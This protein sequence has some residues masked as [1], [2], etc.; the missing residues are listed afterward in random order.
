MTCLRR[1]VAGLL[2]A[3]GVTA[4]A[5]TYPLGLDGD[6]THW[7]MLGYL[8][9]P[10]DPEGC[11]ANFDKEL[12]AELGGEAGIQPAAGQAV[13]VGPKSYVWQL[14]PTRVHTIIKYGNWRPWVQLFHG[15]QGEPL[16]HVAAFL[17]T[18]VVCAEATEGRLMFGTDDGAKLYLNGQL[19][20]RH[21]Q[22]R[23]LIQDDETILLPLRK[24]ANELVFRVE[25]YGGYGGIQARLVDAAGSPLRNVSIELSGVSAGTPVLPARD[26]VS[27]STLIAAIPPV[28]AAENPQPFGVRLART[29]ALLASGRVTRRPVKL[30]FY[31][32]SIDEQ[33]WNTLLVNGLRER[34][35]DTLI[36][37]ENYAIGGWGVPTLLKRF[38][39]D[40][41][42]LQPDLVAFHAYGGTESDWDRLLSAIR[43]ETT[44]DILIRTAHEG[45]FA[46]HEMPRI[47]AMYDSEVLVL[48]GLACRYGAELVEVR[49]EWLNYLAAHRLPAAALLSDAIHLNHKGNVLMAQLYERHFRL[50]PAGG[51]GWAGR[52]RR[53][54]AGRS[55]ADRKQDE[56]TLSGGGWTMVDGRVV[57]AS[58]NDALTLTFVGNRAD[59]VLGPC[60]GSARV[61]ID[62]QPPSALN[63]FHGTGPMQPKRYEQVPGRLIRYFEGAGLLEET[64]ELRFKDVNPD[65]RLFRFTLSG[66]KTGADGEGDNQHEFV[67][68][69]GRIA[70]SP[71]DWIL[72]GMPKPDS[73]QPPLLRWHT[74]ADHR[75]VVRGT[76]GKPREGMVPIVPYTY[77]TLADGL[78]FGRH[79][80]TLI[81]VGDA[82]IG[83]QAVEIHRPPLGVDRG[84]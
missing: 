39:H 28:P 2:L 19:V 21:P 52:V 73:A 41:L 79:T 26:S 29:M 23:P 8:P 18:R 67:S 82:P 44:A 9:I 35:P 75:D 16:L 25:N 53:Y 40:V 48:R 76:P 55:L 42:R 22:G 66:S 20:Y 47:T 49:Q 7:L 81:P 4:M 27:W 80:L 36:V 69:S 71:D 15:A 30:L 12:L 34:Y 62:G 58:T 38:N 24:G 72:G 33:E 59:V 64:W 14:A 5:E 13:T 32:Q 17:Y 84:P 51:D 61:L 50:T 37:A 11:K 45:N 74:V 1:L 60:Q 46:T 70:I 78:P 68:R 77:V 57:S 31:G 10:A 3:G 6:I 83:I 63:L 56:V 65:N 54:E 43:R